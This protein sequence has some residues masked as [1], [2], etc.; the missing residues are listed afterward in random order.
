MDKEMAKGIPTI[1]DIMAEMPT[2]RIVSKKD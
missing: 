1:I 2:I